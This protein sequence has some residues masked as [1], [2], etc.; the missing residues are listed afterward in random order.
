MRQDAF[1]A[2][3]G[4]L[5]IKERF[6]V[7]AREDPSSLSPDLL[8]PIIDATTVKRTRQFVKKHYSGDMIRLPDGT[9]TVIAFPEPRAITVRYPLPDPM[10]AL[11]DRLEAA[12]DPNGRSGAL[13]FARY[14]PECYLRPAEADEDAEEAQGRAAAIMGLL[15]SGLLKRFE[16]SAAAF[17]KTVS[18]LIN[19]HE[20]FLEALGH[21]HVIT[22]RVLHELTG[23]DDETL[24]ELLSARDDTTSAGQYKLTALSRD[25]EAD[26][27]ILRELRE[28]VE[29]VAP[30]VDPKLASILRAL[31]EIAREAEEESVDEE[32][33][34]QKRK[35]IIFSSFADTVAYLRRELQRAIERDPELSCYRGRIVAVSGSSDVE[36]A[37]VGRQHAVS[38]FAPK[39]TESLSSEDRFDILISTDVLAEGLNL[40]QCRHIINY[41]VP[42]NPMRL[43]QR[44]GRIDRIGSPHNRVFLRSTGG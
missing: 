44:H 41:D 42:W 10:P 32:D 30:E 4:I 3:Q 6:E 25:V 20:L 7:A 17:C 18:K 13:T 29:A 36:P 43:V 31:K 28:V 24:D 21:G 5:S 11:F 8:Y 12:L 40:Q 16:S 2:N 23:T 39:S 15:R 9:E 19:E 1:L 27:V 35:V 37:Q 33:A 22:T 34:R 26:L 14:A 38:G